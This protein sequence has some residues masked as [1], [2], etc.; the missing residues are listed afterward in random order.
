MPLSP[1]C[2]TKY[3]FHYH[4]LNA[5]VF[6]VVFPDARIIFQD[7]RAILFSVKWDQHEQGAWS[8]NPWFFH[9]SNPAD[10]WSGAEPEIDEKGRN[11]LTDTVANTG[12]LWSLRQGLLRI[13]LIQGLGLC[14]KTAQN[15]SPKGS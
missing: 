8:K 3:D 13:R 9:N 14:L 1:R 4:R 15:L 6:L 10:H 2:A 11:V 5:A 7:S 12:A